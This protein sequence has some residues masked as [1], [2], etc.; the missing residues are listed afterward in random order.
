M[1]NIK[2]KEVTIKSN[3]CDINTNLPLKLNWLRTWTQVKLNKV[4]LDPILLLHSRVNF[5]PVEHELIKQS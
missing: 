3:M 4:V 1:Y 2:Y 5:D